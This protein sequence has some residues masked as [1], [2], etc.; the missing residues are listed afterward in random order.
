MSV[1]LIRNRDER[2][3][4]DKMNFETDTDDAKNETGLL[5]YMETFDGKFI[6][7]GN[8]L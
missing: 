6:N 8:V 7:I 1:R 2:N 3:T 5:I 4:L